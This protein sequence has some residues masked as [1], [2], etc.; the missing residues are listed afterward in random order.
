MR[1]TP[2]LRI[3]LESIIRSAG[4]VPTSISSHV[5]WDRTFQDLREANGLSRR[6]GIGRGAKWPE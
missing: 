5:I 2:G 3:R 1:Q 4:F 6:S